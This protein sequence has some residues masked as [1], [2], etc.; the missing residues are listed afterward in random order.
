M[1]M[2]GEIKIKDNTKKILHELK[3]V[4]PLALSAIGA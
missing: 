1:E 4:I 2:K 3:E